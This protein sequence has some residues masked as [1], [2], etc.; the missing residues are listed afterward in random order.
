[1]V[2][3]M[4]NLRKKKP[5]KFEGCSKCPSYGYPGGK[6]RFCTEHQLPQM[7]NVFLK[8]C[9]F[10]GCTKTASFAYPGNKALFCKQHKQS[11]M[12]NV[13]RAKK[14]QPQQADQ[15]MPHQKMSYLNHRVDSLACGVPGER[16]STAVAFPMIENRESSR[17][18]QLFSI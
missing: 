16:A 2:S 1:M 8:K 15:N 9:T 10:V 6:A 4:I 18:N 14:P 3:G 7:I 17:P 12:I 5:C 11:E 13:N